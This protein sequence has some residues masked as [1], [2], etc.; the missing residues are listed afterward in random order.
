VLQKSQKSKE[1]LVKVE[2]DKLKSKIVDLEK[3]NEKYILSLREKE[4]VIF[5]FFYISI[6]FIKSLIGMQYLEKLFKN[7]KSHESK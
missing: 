7:P 3:E 6:I 4:K 5:F 1:K 2:F